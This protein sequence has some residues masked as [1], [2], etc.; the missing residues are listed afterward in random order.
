VVVYTICMY[1][2][3]IRHTNGLTDWRTDRR[4]WPDRLGYLSWSR[5]YLIYMEGN[6][7]FYLLNTFQRI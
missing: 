4:N 7:S 1:L 5:I 6:A 2:N 3:D